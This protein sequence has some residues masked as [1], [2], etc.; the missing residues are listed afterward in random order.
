[1]ENKVY[2]KTLTIA[3]IFAVGALMTN[4]ASN[5]ATGQGVIENQSTV[6]PN[7]TETAQDLE[8]LEGSDSA[9]L[10][11]NTDI[12]NPNNTLENSLA[13]NENQSN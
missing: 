10:A 13:T 12:S 9:I 4:I 1:M 2:K 5:T 11:N 8:N 3:L 6:F 7:N